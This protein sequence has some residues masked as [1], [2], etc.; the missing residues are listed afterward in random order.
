MSIIFWLPSSWTLFWYFWSLFTLNF[1]EIQRAPSNKKLRRA[2]IPSPSL[3]GNKGYSHVIGLT[4]HSCSVWGIMIQWYKES[5]Q[6][7]VGQQQPPALVASCHRASCDVHTRLVLLQDFTLILT[8]ACLIICAFSKPCSPVF[9]AIL[10][11]TW[12]SFRCLSLLKSELDSIAWIKNPD[13]YGTY[14]Q[15]DLQAIDP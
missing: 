9:P 12:I 13:R 2:D 7:R 14:C 15:E 8:D 4:S 5:G 11:L 1:G 10:W 3:L 6:Q